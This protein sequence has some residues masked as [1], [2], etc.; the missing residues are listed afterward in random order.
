MLSGT[1]GIEGA[2][3][4]ADVAPGL[5]R[6]QANSKIPPVLRWTGKSKS[7]N[8][9]FDTNEYW[10]SLVSDAR[11]RR[12]IGINWMNDGSNKCL[13]VGN[14]VNA[15]AYSLMKQCIVAKSSPSAS[16]PFSWCCRR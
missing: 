14:E 13:I 3:I 16:P 7:S 10:T 4:A 6:M 12:K 1:F 8:F 9:E 2:L 15:G 11:D 5:L